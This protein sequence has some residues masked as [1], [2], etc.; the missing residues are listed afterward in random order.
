MGYIMFSFGRLGS[1][2]VRARRSSQVVIEI[3]RRLGGGR[4]SPELNMLVTRFVAGLELAATA[5]L[6]VKIL[7]CNLVLLSIVLFQITQ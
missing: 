2:I 3:C 5:E 7:I 1:I 4:R 6:S